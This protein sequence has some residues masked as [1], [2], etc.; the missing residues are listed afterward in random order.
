MS[1]FLSTI[2]VIGAAADPW[3]PSASYTWSLETDEKCW[4][5]PSVLSFLQVRPKPTVFLG[6]RG[7]VGKS[8]C[9]TKLADAYEEIFYPHNNRNAASHLWAKYVFDHASSC[10]DE[11]FKELFEEFC[12]VS[13]SPL[14]KASAQNTYKYSLAAAPG[15][16]LSSPVQGMTHHCCWPC[17]C[18][19]NQRLRVDTKSVTT[20]SGTSQY[21]FLVIGNPCVLSGTPPSPPV[22]CTGASNIADTGCIPFEA[23]GVQCTQQ[24]QLVNATLSDNDHVIVGLF[25]AVDGAYIDYATEEDAEGKKLSSSCAAREQVG[26]DSGMGAIF[27]QVAKLNADFDTR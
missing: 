9:P 23:P 26:F 2:L 19:T 10:T 17:S 5:A 7:A 8:E 22:T 21:N 3:H 27:Q 15:S 13:G 12:P 24:G 6:H 25:E 18:D 16:T 4:M 20:A 11:Q 14:G 1:V